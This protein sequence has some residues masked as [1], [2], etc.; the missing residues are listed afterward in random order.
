MNDFVCLY[1]GPPDTCTECGGFDPTGTGLCGDQDCMDRRADRQE[2]W[3]AA[4]QDRRAREDA[5]GVE[6][7]RLRAAGYTYEQCDQAL[8]HMPT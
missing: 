5:F 4:E 2:R 3:D 1:M 6:V 8:A 7:E